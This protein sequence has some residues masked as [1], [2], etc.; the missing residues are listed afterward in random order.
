MLLS[1]FHRRRYHDQ[2]MADLLPTDKKVDFYFDEHSGAGVL[3]DY[4]DEFLESEPREIRELYGS[5]PRFENDEEFLPLQAADFWAWWVRKGYETGGLD[6]Y[7]SGDFGTW[8][9][10]L[11]INHL[12]ITMS[13]DDIVEEL[14]LQMKRKAGMDFLLNIHDQNVRPRKKALP[15]FTTDRSTILHRIRR[16]M[17]RRR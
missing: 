13:E 15:S 17:K 12:L 4:W 2:K 5:Y 16:M 7:T 9:E 10:N 3:L 8:T 1:L 6:K 14:T 11:H